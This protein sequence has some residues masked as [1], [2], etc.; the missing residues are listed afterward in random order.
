MFLFFDFLCS[1]VPDNRCHK[2]KW[3]VLFFTRI[4]LVARMLACARVIARIKWRTLGRDRVY[5][6]QTGE[7]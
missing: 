6:E 7:K 4:K 2:Q 3:R 1:N 5:W